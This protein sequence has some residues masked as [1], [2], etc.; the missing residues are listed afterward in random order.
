[1]LRKQW[2]QLA[3]T[4]ALKKIIEEL[5]AK[6]SPANEFA[7]LDEL[8]ERTGCTSK[9]L[10]DLRRTIRF[11]DSALT[12]VGNGQFAWSHLVQIEESLVEPLATDFPEV[13]RDIGVKR[14]RTGYGRQSLSQD[15]DGYS[16]FDEQH[17]PR[18]KQ[19][20]TRGTRGTSC[21]EQ[22][23]R[24]FVT[25][26]NTPAEDVLK[27][28]EL[29]IPQFQERLCHLKSGNCGEVRCSCW[30]VEMS[31]PVP[32]MAGF[33]KLSRELLGGLE[34]L[35]KV[36][37]FSSQANEEASPVSKG[38]LNELA[39]TFE[40]SSVRTTR[41]YVA[42]VHQGGFNGRHGGPQFA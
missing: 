39:N 28:F 15:T 13:V 11:S 32:E 18:P 19:S 36:L 40:D 30:L 24:E 2:K 16:S 3:T 20:K 4:R 27:R 23:L 25:D 21:S 17:C 34:E 22:L 33:P 37:V 12:A 10:K 1:M 14:I 38:K 41:V 29:T 42:S 7:L 8:Q 35:Q 9:Q 31:V 6:G 26:H 5:K